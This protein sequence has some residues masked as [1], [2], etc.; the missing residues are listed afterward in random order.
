[1][2]P[3]QITESILA[4][5]EGERLEL[6]RRIVESIAA[7]WDMRDLVSS[8]VGRIEDVVSGR[9]SGLSEGEFRRALG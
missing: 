5:P 7:E 3:T 9:T 1:M 6:A 8:G 2:I 4:L